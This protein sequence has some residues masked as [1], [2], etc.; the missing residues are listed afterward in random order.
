MRKEHIGIK[1]CPRQ[2]T[3][4]F[5]IYLNYEIC[6]IVYNF[7]NLIISQ[8]TVHMNTTALFIKS[9][10]ATVAQDKNEI[11]LCSRKLLLNLSTSKTISKIIFV[12]TT[13]PQNQH[14]IKN[15]Y[16]QKTMNIYIKIQGNYICIKVI[17]KLN[18]THSN[19]LVIIL[20]DSLEIR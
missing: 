16:P 6:C 8:K 17:T 14:L 15:F 2:L 18:A 12:N 20:R 5:L 10:V 3:W 11:L 4:I 9:L 7:H 1:L 19:P 13:N